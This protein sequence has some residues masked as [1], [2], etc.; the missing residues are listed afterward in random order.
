[1][2]DNVPG[3]EAKQGR[4]RRRR[5]RD[6]LRR[7]HETPEEKDARFVNPLRTCLPHF[8]LQKQS[9][10][11]TL[12]I[13]VGW[14]GV[15]KI[16]ELDVMQWV[17]KGDRLHFTNEENVSSLSAVKPKKRGMC[18]I[19]FRSYKQNNW[20]IIEDTSGESDKKS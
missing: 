9:E 14:Q 17:Q 12:I 3:D 6:R 5:E 11:Y 4:L 1:M 20:S 15:G 19:P 2:S 10:L 13:T 8:P 16:T 18:E 7:E